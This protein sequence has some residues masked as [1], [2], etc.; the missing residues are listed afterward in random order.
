M[1]L[2]CCAFTSLN[3]REG[4]YHITAHSQKR[5]ADQIGSTATKRTRLERGIT[6]LFQYVASEDDRI[7]QHT[8][9]RVTHLY[10]TQLSLS[11]GLHSC[12]NH[13]SFELGYSSLILHNLQASIVHKCIYSIKHM[14]S[15][16]YPH[17]FSP[18]AVTDTYLYS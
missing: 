17:P 11:G 9:N 15:C 14:R 7:S 16:S 18:A 12:Q 5:T 4:R 10:Y 2:A 6:P 13:I 1:L 8:Q 3:R